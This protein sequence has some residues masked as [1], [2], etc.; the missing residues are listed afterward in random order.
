MPCV[1]RQRELSILEATA[2]ECRDE[3]VAR[4]MLV[5]GE[6][7]VGKSRLRFELAARL[8]RRQEGWE[9]WL[10]RQSPLSAHAPFGMLAPA[11]RRAAGIR[12]GEPVA[13]RSQKL[14]ARVQRHVPPASVART[15]E[16]LGELAGIPAEGPESPELEAARRDP[17][18]MGDQI[19]RAFVELSAA[20][21]A[22]H[23][24]L[25]AVD[26]LQWGD[27][28][29]LELCDTVLRVHP[30]LPIFVVALGRPEVH[31]VFPRLWDQRGVQELR[32]GGLTRRAAEELVRQA[33]GDRVDAAGVAAIVERSGGNAFFLEE[34]VRVAAEGRVGAL[35][36]TVLAMVQ[37]RLEALDP[38]ARRVLRAASVYGAAFW[39]GGVGALLG[40]AAERPAA[41]ERALE[42][43]CE[44]ELVYHRADCRFPR[45]H[46]Y[47]F[48]SLTVREA[49]YALLTPEDQ[50]LGHRLA[51]AWLERAGESDPS[52]L[53]EHFARGG[54]AARAAVALGRAAAQALEAHDFEAAIARA[55][56]GLELGAVGELA[57]ELGLC[58]AEGARWLGRFAEGVEHALRAAEH[59]TP[60]TAAWYRAAEELLTAHLRLGRFASAPLWAE[61]L[62]TEPHAEG[63]ASARVSAM[64]QAARVLFQSG[65]YRG[66]GALTTGCER[67]L[68][69]ATDLT[70]RARAEVHRL[71]GARARHAGDVAGDFEGYR[72]ALEHGE[73]GDEREACNARVS[74]GFAYVE[75]GAYP[76][77][78]AT[79]EQALVAARAM[80]L[81]AVVTRARQNLALVAAAE[82]DLG[83]ATAL[84]LAV[85]A[86][87]QSHGDR[88]LE[89][90]T[91]IYLGRFA[92]QAGDH[93]EAASQA[94]RAFALLDPNAPARVGA[95]AV[96]AR[97]ALGLGHLVRAESAAR[98]AMRLLAS[99]EGIEE[100]EALVRLAYVEVMSAV[101]DD[102]EA[103]AA[104]EAA[105]VRLRATASRLCDPHLR[106]SFL[107]RVPEN[108]ALFTRELPCPSCSDCIALRANGT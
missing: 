32:L 37:A 49:A 42:L 56:R 78:R 70:P 100:L 103:A 91:R 66:A 71:H 97:A 83:G 36:E 41:L 19:R 51:G 52:T 10:C 72:A 107:E 58:A 9:V 15:C 59:A 85:L 65:D 95:L 108:R 3:S 101:G 64:C 45:E 14:R 96:L 23:P 35:P 47:A 94:R 50:R 38:E 88:Q 44:R 90:W 29:S 46:E 106:R 11:L 39:H 99:F 57:A 92:A 89:A 105:R 8:L 13:L 81:D 79:L 31:A 60:G 21:A 62:L 27:A 67:L 22:A 43:L 18:L 55:R 20:E 84:A 28:P 86:E 34:L 73:A 40:R 80:G 25:I 75:L 1:G 53:A 24:L 63:A 61:R 16:F 26:D 76:E 87:T 93:A 98:A 82:G 33:L 69:S 17:L 77:A 12:D 7:G 102:A 74:L 68:A 2:T 54:E 5:T 48:R 4:A 104:L 6:A 30:E